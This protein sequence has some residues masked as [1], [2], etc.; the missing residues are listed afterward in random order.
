MDQ[1]FLDLNFEP[2]LQEQLPWAYISHK[3]GVSTKL[4]DMIGRNRSNGVAI[5]MVTAIRNSAVAKRCVGFSV[6]MLDVLQL[7]H[8]STDVQ[9]P[10]CSTDVQQKHFL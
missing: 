6:H 1:N 10:H 2:A 4:V 5:S 8:C 7:P 3:S 9:L